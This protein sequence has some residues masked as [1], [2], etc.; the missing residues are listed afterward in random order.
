VLLVNYYSPSVAGLSGT[1]TALVLSVFQGKYRPTWKGMRAALIEG[2]VLVSL[3]SLLLIAIGP[4]GQAFQTTNLSGKLGI[5]LISILPDSKIVLLVGAAVLSIVLGIGLPTPVAYLIA[6][7]AVV[8]FMIQIGIPALQAHYFAFYFAI[9]ATLSPPVAES[10]LAAA[11]LAGSGFY[12]TGNHAMKLAATTFIIPFAFVFNPE[13]MAFPNFS[14]KMAWAVAEVL[15][16]QWTSSVF[17]YGHF[18]RRLGFLERCGFG[19]A[20]LLGYTAIMRPEALYTYLA[21]GMTLALMA[22]IWFRAAALAKTEA[23]ASSAA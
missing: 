5:W 22:W 10:V 15:I 23:K 7:L 3:L 8:P 19:I 9:Y 4:L 21:Y 12:E 17:L 14:W 16:V 20:V 11:K 18:V 13:L 6:A 2:I 1:A